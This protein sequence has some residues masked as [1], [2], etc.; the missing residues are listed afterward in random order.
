MS[1]TNFQKV[2]HFNKTFGV[3]THNTL[4]KNIFDKD[5]KLVQLRLDLITEEVQ[6]LKDAIKEKDM[7]ETID[8]LT[9]ILYVVYGAGSSFGINLDKSFDIVHESNMSKLCR[10]EEVAKETVEWY[11]KEYEEGRLPY[12]TPTYRKDD[13]SDKYIVYNES[14][15]KIIKSREYN[16]VNFSKFKEK[17]DNTIK[18]KSKRKS[19]QKTPSKNR[20]KSKN[21]SEEKTVVKSEE[22]TTVKSEEEPSGKSEEET[23]VKS[24]EEPS[25]KSEEETTGKSEEEEIDL[26]SEEFLQ[27]KLVNEIEYEKFDEKTYYKKEDSIFDDEDYKIDDSMYPDSEDKYIEVPVNFEDV[28]PLMQEMIMTDPTIM[29]GIG[30]A[31]EDENLL[32]HTLIAGANYKFMFNNDMVIKAWRKYKLDRFYKNEKIIRFFRSLASE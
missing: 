13:K 18:D 5:P 19:K 25:G 4:Q 8:A 17:I 21:K 31:I 10:N 1:L 27:N 26:K 20:R 6:E 16:A 22:E 11:K 7:N 2:D 3:T 12:D 9:D 24:E 14:T 15:G 32:K 23:T 28:H 29:F 30:G